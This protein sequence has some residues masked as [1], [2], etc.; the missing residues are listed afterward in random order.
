MTRE[1]I[2]A[3]TSMEVLSPWVTL[4]A[5]TV[6][7]PD[8]D[9][10]IFH[11]LGIADYVSVLAVTPDG[12]IPLVRQYRPA[13][14][15]MTIELPGGLNEAS[16]APAEVAIRELYEETG[17]RAFSEPLLLGRLI[18]D[19]GRLENRLWCYF[20][21]ASYDTNWVPEP[22]VERVIYTRDQLRSNILNGTFDH[23]LHVALIGLALM[24][25]CFKWTG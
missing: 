7:K 16:E 24:R 20:V 1:I 2:L 11:S 9:P 25:G 19:T 23:A 18:P 10:Q 21:T 12:M 3:E 5:R 14:Q 22:S 4:L 8:G 17:F 15:R 6:L 13:V